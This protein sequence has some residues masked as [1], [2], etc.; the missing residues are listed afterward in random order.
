MQEIAVLEERKFTFGDTEAPQQ[1]VQRSQSWLY[2]EKNRDKHVA[3]SSTSLAVSYTKYQDFDTLKADFVPILQKLAAM[4]PC[5]IKRLGLRYI[6]KFDFLESPDPLGWREY[7]DESLVHALGIPAKTSCSG[8]SRALNWVELNYSDWSLRFQ[9][10]IPNPDYP[11]LLK[12]NQFILDMD[13]HSFAVNS[14]LEVP[15]WLGRFHDEIR[16][17]FEGVIKDTLRQK[18]EV[19]DAG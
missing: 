9:F 17:L 14:P 13:A 7:F 19:E 5:V 6:D 10:G 3:I 15:D 11:A 16:R 1:S 8:I 2:W 12:R 4:Y 18:L